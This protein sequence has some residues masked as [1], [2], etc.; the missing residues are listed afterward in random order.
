MLKRTALAFLSPTSSQGTTACR[1]FSQQCNRGPFDSMLYALRQMKDLSQTDEVLRL[2]DTYQSDN[3]RE[4]LEQKHLCGEVVVHEAEGYEKAWLTRPNDPFLVGLYRWQPGGATPLHDHGDT[5]TAYYKII[6]DVPLKNI[7]Y[8]KGLAEEPGKF[9]VRYMYENEI[10]PWKAIAILPW[11]QAHIVRN[12]S[13]DD[14]YS[15]HIY[16]PKYE[17]CR[18]WKDEKAIA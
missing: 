6:G 15:I 18:V 17:W 5:A 2:L 13:K 4:I 7:V 10:T 3:F 14:A 8:S 9:N 1:R 11:R 12:D 16:T